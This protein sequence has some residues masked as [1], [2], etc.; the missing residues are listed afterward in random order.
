MTRRL[1]PLMILVVGTAVIA[2]LARPAEAAPATLTPGFT[3][4]VRLAGN[5]A[6]FPDDPDILVFSLGNVTGGAD[7]Q[8]T[9]VLSNHGTVLG[10]QADGET[11]SRFFRSASSLWPVGT[12]IDFSSFAR[13]SPPIDGLVEL[14]V[15]S[16]TVSIEDTSQIVVSIGRSFAGGGANFFGTLVQSVEIVAA[17]ATI[18]GAVGVVDSSKWPID[19]VDAVV[20]VWALNIATGQFHSASVTKP[21]YIAAGLPAGSYVVLVVV[22]YT[23]DIELN[24]DGCGTTVVGCLGRTIQKSLLAWSAV[25]TIQTGIEHTVDINLPPVTVMVHGIGIPFLGGGCYT[26]WYSDTN[27]DAW[28]NTARA[29][30]V[31][32]FTPNYHFITDGNWILRAAQVLDQVGGNLDRLTSG[33]ATWGW[34]PWVVIAHSQGGL[35][36]RAMLNALGTHQRV[37]AL[38]RLYMLGTPNS[39]AGENIAQLACVPELQPSSMTIAFNTTYPGFVPLASTDVVAF[40]GAKYGWTDGIVDVRSVFYILQ[41][42]CGTCPL[43]VADTVDY[44]DIFPAYDHLNLGDPVSVGILK[45]TILP[46]IKS[47]R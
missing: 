13:S 30:G 46:G 16:G 9:V 10:T 1:A 19:G 5:P 4:K 24:L 36:A 3:L 14:R 2:G 29:N 22:S 33:A 17:G 38:K 42:A 41:K 8:V 31:I 21:T 44:G 26:K 43:I 28:D 25:T 7:L 40:A 47:I 32:S 23:D 35:V 15:V 34:P 6:S 11:F 27:P 18:R 12:I 45:N 37:Q 39:G 20:S